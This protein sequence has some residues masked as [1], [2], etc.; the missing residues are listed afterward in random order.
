MVHIDGITVPKNALNPDLGV[1]FVHFMLSEEGQNV[2][3][4][5][6]RPPSPTEADALENVP[7]DLR[8]MVV[9]EIANRRV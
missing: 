4:E 3:R 8:D 5:V 2:L 7:D 9:N 6:H 1:A